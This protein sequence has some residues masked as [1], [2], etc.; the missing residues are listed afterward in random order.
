MELWTGA[1]SRWKCYWPDLKSAG[2]FRRNLFLNCINTVPQPP[3]RPDLAPCD[4]GLF[5]KFRGSRYK[6]IEE[7]KEAVTKVIDTLTQED[8]H[9]SFQK[10]LERYK[11]IAAGGDYFEGDYSLMCVLSIKMSIRKKSANLF[12]D[13]RKWCKFWYIKKYFYESRSKSSK[14]HS[15]R[16]AITEHF[17]CSNTLPLLLKL[18]KIIQIS[19]LISGHVKPTERL[20][21]YDKSKNRLRF[22]IFGKNLAYFFFLSILL[23]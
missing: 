10:L 4:F 8:F 3:Y 19:F 14:P 7:L 2:L 9:G 11:C 1:L 6:T 17:C 22:R 15:E 5:P 21:V 12:N 13:P 16:R 18:E 20:A 23:I